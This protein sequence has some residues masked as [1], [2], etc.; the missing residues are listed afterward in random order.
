MA[1]VFLSQPNLLM[2]GPV[3]FHDLLVTMPQGIPFFSSSSNINSMPWYSTKFSVNLFLYFERN[4][5]LRFSISWSEYAL[6]QFFRI[7]V[8][9]RDENFLT[10]SKSTNASLSSDFNSLTI[11]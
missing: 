4:L 5:Y 11:V 8:A 1:S 2:I 6:K 3:Y 7:K 9:P 10:G